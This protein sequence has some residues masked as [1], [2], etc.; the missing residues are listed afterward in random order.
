MIIAE[1]ERLCT[2]NNDEIHNWYVNLLPI[3]IH[4]RDWLKNFDSNT[5][6][7]TEFFNFIE[8]VMYT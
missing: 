5:K 7:L 2:M 4:N 8:Q 1:V 3:L 6:F